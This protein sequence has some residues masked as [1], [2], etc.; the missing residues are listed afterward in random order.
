VESS[1]SKPHPV[2]VARLGLGAVAVVSPSLLLRLAQGPDGRDE[3]V[4]VRIL[5]ARYLAQAAAGLVLDGPRVRDVDAAVDLIHA[6]TMV[7]LATVAPAHRRLALLS[8]VT[9]S[10][11]AAADLR[12]RAG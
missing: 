8:A 11:L 5:G 1:V 6:T 12:V 2:D 9:A 7:A 4:T 3:R 10:G